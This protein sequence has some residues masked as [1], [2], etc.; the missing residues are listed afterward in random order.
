[1][2]PVSLLADMS[3]GGAFGSVPVIGMFSNFCKLSVRYSGVC[4]AIW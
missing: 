1:M 3:D 2:K 4:V